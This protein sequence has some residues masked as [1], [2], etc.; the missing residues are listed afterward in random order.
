MAVLNGVRSWRFVVG[1]VSLCVLFGVIMTANGQIQI[2]PGPSGAERERQ[3][4]TEASR[5]RQA[6]QPSQNVAAHAAPIPRQQDSWELVQ[7]GGTRIGYTHMSIKPGPK[8]GLVATHAETRLTLKRFGQKMQIVTVLKTVEEDETGKLI[9]FEHETRNP[10]ASIQRRSGRVEGEFLHFVRE[11]DGQNTARQIPWKSDWKSPS[12]QQRILTK[13]MIS[14]KETIKFL[15]FMPEFEKEATVTIAAK[16]GKQDVKL[17]DGST[18]SL[19]PVTVV[20]SLLPTMPVTAYVNQQGEALVSESMLVGQ[21][22]RLDRVSASEALE[23]IAGDELDI[24]VKTLV[25]VMPLPRPHQTKK[26]VYRVT[27]ESDDP[28]ELLTTDPFQQV[29]REE[30]GAR[31][32]CLVTVTAVELPT[33]PVQLAKGVPGEEYLQ[34]NSHIQSDDAHVVE[35]ARR[36]AGSETDPVRIALAMEKYVSRELRSKNFSSGLATAAEVARSMEGDCTEHAVLLAAMLRTRKIPSRVAVGLVYLRG[37]GAMG[38]HM[39]TEAYLGDQWIP[40]DATLGNGGTG[41]GHLKL[42]NSSF[43]DDGP[44]PLETFLPV[45]EFLGRATVEVVKVE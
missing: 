3:Q 11:V 33:G 28:T 37:Q 38:A 27:M 10:P 16:N 29:E 15:A 26:I 2:T 23:Q 7:L 42:A 4:Q 45:M 39:W 41:A 13:Q 24:A 30:G 12:W 19:L 36:A 17:F 32:W 22:M 5:Q 40:L 43:T 34:P 8:P 20:S 9:S 31:N 14:P 1:T 25:D 44:A 6:K 21:T 35:H 18:E